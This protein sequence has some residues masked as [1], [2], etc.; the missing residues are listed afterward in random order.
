MSS[1]L[2]PILRMDSSAVEEIAKSGR[3]PVYIALTVNKD[4]CEST[5]HLLIW[6]KPEY[7][8]HAEQYFK[9][10][11]DST[12]IEISRNAVYRV[13]IYLEPQSRDYSSYVL[14]W[15]GL[16]VSMGELLLSKSNNPIDKVCHSARSFQQPTRAPTL[17]ALSCQEARTESPSMTSSTS[18]TQRTLFNHQPAIR[19]KRWCVCE[20][21]MMRFDTLVLR[22]RR[23]PLAKMYGKRALWGRMIIEVVHETE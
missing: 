19:M 3:K 21:P 20:L 5:H 9:L 6:A 18:M 10:L 17:M 12:R 23:N 1:S 8:V 7:S 2:E 13:Q 14:E 11:A 16:E 22:R 4:V 15:N